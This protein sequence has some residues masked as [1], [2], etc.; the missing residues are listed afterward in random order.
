MS[1]K[2]PNNNRDKSFH[3]FKKQVRLAAKAAD[4]LSVRNI[5]F[6][7]KYS[8]E[9]GGEVSVS[10]PV[11]KEIARFAVLVH[12]LAHHDSEINAKV[13]A[14]KL[15]LLDKDNKETQEWL[16][17]IIE[18]CDALER[19]FIKVNYNNKDYTAKDMFADASKGYF[20]SQNNLNVITEGLS[21]DPILSRLLVFN[22]YNYCFEVFKISIQILNILVALKANKHPS[23][24][25]CN[26]TVCIFC[27]QSDRPFTSS[28][29]IFPESLG[30][31]ELVL[32]PGVVCDICNNRTLSGL[33]NYLVQFDAIN[34]LRV[35]HLPYNPKT[36][37]FPSA[38][39][40]N[41]AIE[42]IHP[43]KVIIKPRHDKYLKF[44][45]EGEL[46]HITGTMIGRKKFYPKV[47]AR[48]LFKIALEII[49][50]TEGAEKALVARYDKA[51][52]FIL[53]G[54][55]FRNY[56]AMNSEINTED[57]TI[58]YCYQPLQQGS[59]FELRIFG[60]IFIFNIE[61]EPQLQPV[62]DVSKFGLQVF[63]LFD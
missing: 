49:A 62:E 56:I 52:D 25:A 18:R 44:R 28:E 26:K 61:E 37:K 17:T 15:T 59:L 13:I 55:D 48:S 12:P 47:L 9:E 60:L 21:A 53:K 35:M 5:S 7:L 11:E 41:M 34:F 36:G 27:K 14:H 58:S 32:E 23:H 10:L 16:S 20:F 24:N 38:N 1:R 2:K 50:L 42:K 8:K 6:N 29:H 43:Q 39:F 51:R 4:D 33:D 30:N 3:L 54:G 63:P 45:K 40:Q 46:A 31:N 57:G 19:G 22:F